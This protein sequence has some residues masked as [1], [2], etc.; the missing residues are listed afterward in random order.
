MEN[1]ISFKRLYFFIET[2][3]LENYKSYFINLAALN[4]FFFL[5]MWLKFSEKGFSYETYLHL[6]PFFYFLMG[7]IFTSRIFTKANSKFLNH[8][9]LMLPVSNFEKFFGL[10]L[11]STIVYTIA[12]FSIFSLT[13]A[14]IT[15]YFHVSAKLSADIF[16]PF[17]ME[18]LNIFSSYLVI[19][20][21]FFF[22]AV[23][24]K[25][26]NFVKTIISMV[27]FFILLM[28][29]SAWFIFK[30]ENAG[31]WTMNFVYSFEDFLLY[32]GNNLG[33]SFTSF[34]LYFILIPFF[35]GVSFY[36]MKNIEVKDGV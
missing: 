12:Y 33:I 23:F 17:S 14:L 25:K 29:S 19:H 16:N 13:T 32:G 24:F 36:K 2:E 8:D 6:F 4:L 27:L 21:V 31:S 22:G 3:I 15:L 20:C 10:L 11:M 9:F 28:I 5:I 18:V 7:L 35:W 30:F 34:F 26:S 1:I